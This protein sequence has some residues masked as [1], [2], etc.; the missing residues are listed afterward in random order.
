MM[1]YLSQLGAEQ[2]RG[3]HTRRQCTGSKSLW[4]VK[5]N[6][7]ELALLLLLGIY[8]VY[9]FDEALYEMLLYSITISINNKY[10]FA[11]VLVIFILNLHY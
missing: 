1:I 3:R 9:V 8:G 7:Q 6:C 10:I 5:S 11:T 4:K 2:E